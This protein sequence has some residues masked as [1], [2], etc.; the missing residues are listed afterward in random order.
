MNEHLSKEMKKKIV[1]SRRIFVLEMGM[2]QCE[3]GL[4]L[5]S[6]AYFERNRLHKRAQVHF[7]NAGEFSLETKMLSK[8][9][10]HPTSAST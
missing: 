1:I 6:C 4:P 8:D 2:L 10:E 5:R 3:C 9:T 7:V